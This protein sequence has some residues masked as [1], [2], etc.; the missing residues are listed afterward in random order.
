MEPNLFISPNIPHFP[1]L[2]IKFFYTTLNYARQKND[3]L[4][5]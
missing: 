1:I 4:A 2:F 5:Q 3:L